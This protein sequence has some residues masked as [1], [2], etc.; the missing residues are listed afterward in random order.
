MTISPR[1]Y[2]WWASEVTAFANRAANVMRKTDAAIGSREALRSQEVGQAPKY[3]RQGSSSQN[4]K[5]STV[6][7]SIQTCMPTGR[8]VVEAAGGVTVYPARA[9][10]GTGGGRHGMRAGGGGS[11]SR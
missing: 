10:R 3:R 11:A 4:P 9:G 1:C 2:R 5:D 7:A 6:I 8:V